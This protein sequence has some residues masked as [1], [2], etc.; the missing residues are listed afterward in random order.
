V[1]NPGREALTWIVNDADTATAMA[2]SVAAVERGD[3]VV[4]LTRR[5]ERLEHLSAA[6]GQRVQ[7][8]PTGAEDRGRLEQAIADAVEVFGRLDVLANVSFYDT[9]GIVAEL[10]S[11]EVRK[12][13]EANVFGSLDV[14]RATLPVFRAQRFGH[15]VQASPNDGGITQPSTGLL[16]ATVF[17][18]DGFTGVLAKELA[19]FGVQVSLVDLPL[20]A[21]RSRMA[22]VDDVVDDITSSPT[23]LSDQGAAAVALILATVDA[24]LPPERFVGSREAGEDVR[25]ARPRLSTAKTSDE[26]GGESRT[27]FVACPALMRA[28]GSRS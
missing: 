7:V 4:A 28:E 11:G 25:V 14:L 5:V 9:R 16:T 17:A 10:S 13:F 24:K 3:N 8:I 27:P 19:P 1:S 22:A 18:M 26:G 21:T 12:V 20:A 15:V 6:H 23:S 2:L